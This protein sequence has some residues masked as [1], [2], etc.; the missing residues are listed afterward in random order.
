MLLVGTKATSS[1]FGILK[2]F[3]VQ[4]LM[5]GDFPPFLFPVLPPQEYWYVYD[6]DRR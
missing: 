5:Q 3:L 2:R 6:G 1:Y 4:S